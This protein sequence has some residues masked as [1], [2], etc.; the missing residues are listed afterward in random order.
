MVA[1]IGALATDEVDFNDVEACGDIVPLEEVEPVAHTFAQQLAF[2]SIHS[3]HGGAAGGRGAAFDLAGDQ[4][5]ALTAHDIELSAVAV[6]E[7]A[8]QYF[9]A[10]RPQVRGSNQLTILTQ[11]GTGRRCIRTPGAAQPVQQVQTSG[12]GVE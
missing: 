1:D 10:L 3:A 9:A 2:G 8:A 6:A 5:I 4:H 11:P 7:I 12:D